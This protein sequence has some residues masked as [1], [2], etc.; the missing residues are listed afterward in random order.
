MSEVA[1]QNQRPAHDS[2]GL[3][4]RVIYAIFPAS[5]LSQQAECL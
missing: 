2:I 4:N 1:Q 3:T 5:F